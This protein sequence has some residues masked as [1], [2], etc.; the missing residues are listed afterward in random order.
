VLREYVAGGVEQANDRVPRI[1]GDLF[2]TEDLQQ[3]VKTFL[4]QGPGNARFTGR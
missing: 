4:A 3:A 2:A 1:G